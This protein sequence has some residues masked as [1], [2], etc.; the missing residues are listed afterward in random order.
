VHREELVVEVWPDDV[1]LRP[2]QLQPHSDGGKPAQEEEDEDGDDV[3]PA[4]HLVVDAR[5]APDQAGS[6]APGL[7][8]ATAQLGIVER[9]V[10]Q[11]GPRRFEHKLAHFSPSR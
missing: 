3:A 4:D 1:V 10:A 11:L 6:R 2:R 9:R 8:E 5:E 7:G